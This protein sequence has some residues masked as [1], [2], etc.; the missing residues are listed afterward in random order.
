MPTPPPS[1][2]PAP[3]ALPEPPLDVAPTPDVAVCVKLLPNPAL[4]EAA[5]PAPIEL[6]E[7][8]AQPEPKP[9]ELRGAVV[10]GTLIPPPTVWKP[11]T[12]TD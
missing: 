11:A 6:A 5:E 2:K 1:P 4:F 12:F 8:K 10:S 9:D 7:P 3:I